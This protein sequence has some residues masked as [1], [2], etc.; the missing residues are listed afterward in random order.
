MDFL[1][2]IAILALLG[3]VAAAAGIESRDAFTA[4]TYWEHHS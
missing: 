1:A 4:D 3:L 2:V